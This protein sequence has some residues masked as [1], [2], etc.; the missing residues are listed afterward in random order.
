M[1]EQ[2][3]CLKYVEQKNRELGTQV[4]VPVICEVVGRK[5]VQ[6]PWLAVVAPQPLH[7]GE[8]WGRHE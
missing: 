4:R 8:I 7:F 6:V 5:K 3:V 2:Y 1:E